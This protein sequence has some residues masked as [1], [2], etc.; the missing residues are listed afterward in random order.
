MSHSL[1]RSG[2]EENLQ[3]DYTF[4]ARSSRYVNRKGCGLKLHKIFD[5][6]LSEAPVNYGHSERSLKS[7][8]SIEE[9]ADSLDNASGICGCFSDKRIL[10][11]F[12]I[13]YRQA[14][15]GIS[16]VISG[17]IDEIVKLAEALDLKPHTAFLSLGGH[18]KKV[19]LPEDKILEITAMRG[20][21]MVSSQLVTAVAIKVRSGEMS[22]R[23]GAD[24]L[25]QPCPCGIFNTDRCQ[26]LI[27]QLADE[28][29][30]GAVSGT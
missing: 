23:E 12:L 28:T 21:G 3:N 2:T 15:T 10:K 5:V 13:K 22:L 7:G 19:L 16:L 4:Y 14:Q 24:Q 20:H 30:A 27:S 25:A 9:Y 18:G 6:M 17:L 8:L 11:S 29:G 1:H 26:A